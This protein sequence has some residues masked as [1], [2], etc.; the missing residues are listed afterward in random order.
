M[1]QQGTVGGVGGGGEEGGAPP[2]QATAPAAVTVAQ[3][4]C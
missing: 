1:E 2:A 4:S 3:V